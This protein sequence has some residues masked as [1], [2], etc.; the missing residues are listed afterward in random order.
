MI[1]WVLRFL[2]GLCF[3]I[4]GGIDGLQNDSLW[5]RL[6]FWLEGAALDF[7]DEQLRAHKP[8]PLRFLR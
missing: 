8:W 5:D 3:R 4:N 6:Y 2:A 7:S 1:S